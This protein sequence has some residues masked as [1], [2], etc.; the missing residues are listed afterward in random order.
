M[1]IISPPSHADVF[2]GRGVPKLPFPLSGAPSPFH[3]SFRFV[4]QR[5]RNDRHAETLSRA[6]SRS[7]IAARSPIPPERRQS[8]PTGRDP[9]TH[10]RASGNSQIIAA[11]RRFHSSRGRDSPWK[12]SFPF[13][14]LLSARATWTKTR[15]SRRSPSDRRALPP[16]MNRAGNAGGNAQY[17][18]AIGLLPPLFCRGRSFA[19]HRP[20]PR[21]AWRPRTWRGNNFRSGARNLGHSAFH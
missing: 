4:A 7:S 16:A 2:T 6:R 10:S 11:I 14:P 20:D 12:R 9:L 1:A 21:A 3:P 15:E 18:R 19:P 8:C 5:S 13:P 17:A